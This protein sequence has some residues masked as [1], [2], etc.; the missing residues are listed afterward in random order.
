MSYVIS[1]MSLFWVAF[2]IFWPLPHE[3]PFPFSCCSFASYS[4]VKSPPTMGWE[5][6]C[7]YTHVCGFHHFFLLHLSSADIC[8]SVRFCPYSPSNP[9]ARVCLQVSPKTWKSSVRSAMHAYCPICIYARSP[10]NSCMSIL[11]PCFCNCQ[12]PLSC[13]SSSVLN[14]IPPASSLHSYVSSL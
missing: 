1:H 9:S 3:P 11:F 5:S 12:H 8:L 2:E 10:L 14:A 6:I 4:H 13:V 7:M